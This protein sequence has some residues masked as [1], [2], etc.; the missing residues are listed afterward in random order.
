MSAICSEPNAIGQQPVAT[1]TSPVLTAETTRRYRTGKAR[2][3]SLAKRLSLD[4]SAQL[5]KPHAIG[6]PHFDRDVA[7]KPLVLHIDDD[8]DLV[9]AMS[10]R[11]KAA[12][13]ETA[14]ALDGTTGFHSALMH[15]ASVIILDY[16]MPNG[17]GD[18]VIKLLRKNERTADIPVIVLTA[19]QKKSLRR[20]LLS[21]GA[22]VFMTKPFDFQEL[23]S[24]I[25][26]LAGIGP[27][28]PG[29]NQ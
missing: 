2:G 14:C 9:D 1:A 17:R 3:Y 12:G 24:E 7:Q 20:K 16:D 6:K 4:E 29:S 25:E 11:L 27:T 22:N 15:P 13:F 19:L 21:M 18:S 28:E 8:S 23:R 10:A 5:D 26:R